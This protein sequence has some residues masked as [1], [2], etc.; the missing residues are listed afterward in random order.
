MKRS[1]VMKQFSTRLRYYVPVTSWLPN[2]SIKTFSGDA[3]SAL[4]MTSLIVPQSISYALSLANLPA[5]TGELSIPCLDILFV[6]SSESSGLFG[7][8]I[9]P[10][11]YS[12]L[13]TSRYAVLL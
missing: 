8:A 1:Q 5:V 12:L 4:T 3:T 10:I 13:G 2:Y 9:P 11:I 7:A 6:C